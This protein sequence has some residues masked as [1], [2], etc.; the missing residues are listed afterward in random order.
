MMFYKNN[1]LNIFFVFLLCL[2]ANVLAQDQIIITPDYTQSEIRTKR[3]GL[4]VLVNKAEDLSFSGNVFI[5]F[6]E[7]PDNLTAES[8]GV[9]L[10]TENFNEKNYYFKRDNLDAGQTYYYRWRLESNEIGSL[11]TD[12]LSFTTLNGFG[13]LPGQVFELPEFANQPGRDLKEGDTIGRLKYDDLAGTW[14][15]VKTYFKTTMAL[16]ENGELWAWGRN[17]TKLVP[18]PGNQSEVIYEPSKIQNFSDGE[19]FQ[20]LV[21]EDNDGYWNIDEETAGTNP[22]DPDSIP[23]DTDQDGFSDMF[24]DSLGLDKNDDY[25]TFKDWEKLDEAYS[26]MV[27]LQDLYFYDFDFS[28]SAALGIE[29]N[30][31]NLYFWGTANGGGYISSEIEDLNGDKQGGRIPVMFLEK[32]SGE[33]IYYE[34]PV[35]IDN[36]RR[37][38]KIAVS[39]NYLSPKY[40]NINGLDNIWDTSVAGITE[41]G[42]LFIWGIV[43]GILLYEPLQVGTGYKW[44]DIAVAEGIVAITSN[45]ELFEV[46]ME[47]PDKPE[48][49]SIDLDGDG[50]PD[51]RDKF[52][53]DYN[54]QYDTD[55]DGL[56]DKYE[57]RVS[58]TNSNNRDTDGD[59]V[60]DG[61]DELPNDPSSS[62]D[63]D[64]DGLSAEKEKN[65]GDIDF[66]GVDG[67]QDPDRDGD[68]IP[69]G[70]DADPDDPN[71]KLDSDGDG[72]TDEQEWENFSD[73]FNPDSDQDGVG[74]FDDEFPGIWHYQNDSDGDGLPDK[75]ELIN[76]TNP[77]EIDSDGDG[78]IDGID[79]QKFDEFRSLAANLSCEGGWERCDQYYY[80]W[81]FWDLK[82]DCN[83]DGWISGDEWDRTSPDCE[84]KISRDDYPSDAQFTLDSDNDRE[85]DEIDEDDDNDGF[86]DKIEDFLGTDSKND[87]DRPEDS[88]DDRI[89][90]QIEIDGYVDQEGNQVYTRGTDQFNRDTDGDGAWDGWDDWPLDPRIS[91]DQDKDFIEDWRE[92]YELKTDHKNP[93]T[94]GD[95]VDDLYDDFPLK[96]WVTE[97]TFDSG[98]KDSD[99][100][101]LSDEYED[102]IAGLDKF[103]PD[104][105]GDGFEDGP[106]VEG[107]QR[108]FQNGEFVGW[109][110]SWERCHR[111]GENWYFDKIDNRW[112]NENSWIQDFFPTDNNNR[113]DIDG[114]GIPDNDDTDTDGDG[115]PNEEDDLPEDPTEQINTDKPTIENGGLTDWSW[116]GKKYAEENGT[117]PTNGNG[118]FGEDIDNDGWIDESRDIGWRFDFVGNNQDQDDDGDSFLD[119]DE[120]F[121]GTDPLDRLSFPGSSFADH[122]NDGLSTNFE[123]GVRI[124]K[125]R[126][127]N[128][129]N[130]TLIEDALSDEFD[131]PSVKLLND[132]NQLSPT[133]QF[134]TNFKV[135]NESG[136]VDNEIQ[137]KLYNSLKSFLPK[138]LTYDEFISTSS[139]TIGIIS[140][141]LRKSDPFNWDTDGDGISDGWRNPNDLS[142]DSSF[143]RFV[144]EIPSLEA[145]L[146]QG[147]IFKLK[148]EPYDS[149][150]YNESILKYEFSAT[151]STTTGLQLLQYFKEAIDGQL[152]EVYNNSGTIGSDLM[153]AT[154]SKTMLIVQ[155]KFYSGHHMGRYFSYN[156]FI[157]TL[158]NTSGSPKL[159][160]FKN[161]G[162]QEHL[163]V[164]FEDKMDTNEFMLGES[165]FREIRFK[166]GDVSYD[167]NDKFLIDDFPSD[168]SRYIDTD[169]DGLDDKEDNDIDGDGT[170]N[171][172]DELPWDSR[173]YKDIDNDGIPDEFDFTSME[174]DTDGDGMS[175]GDEI[176]LKLNPKNWDTDGDG[177]SDGGTYPSIIGEEYTNK[178]LIIEIDDLDAKVA[179]GEKFNIRFRVGWN[180]DHLFNIEYSHDSDRF[181]TEDYFNSFNGENLLSYFNFQINNQPEFSVTINIQNSEVDVK[182]KFSSRIQRVEG[183]KKVRLIIEWNKDFYVSYDTFGTTIE[184]N[185]IYPFVENF[186]QGGS[187][188]KYELWGLERHSIIDDDNW[189]KINFKNGKVIQGNVAGKKFI[190]AYPLDPDK[191]WDTDEDG[192]AD[193]YDNNI[194]GDDSKNSE[195]QVPYDNREVNDKDQ[196]GIGDTVDFT[197][198]YEDTDRDG[199]TNFYELE[200]SN[201]DPLNWDTDGDGVP[202]GPKYPHADV[203]SNRGLGLSG[204]WKFVVLV[205]NLEAKTISNTTYQIEIKNNNQTELITYD[206]PDVITGSAL[207]V[208]FKDK[209]NALSGSIGDDTW[210]ASI[211]NNRLI[212]KGNDENPDVEIRTPRILINNRNEMFVK[213]SDN[214]NNFGSLPGFLGEMMFRVT[215]KNNCC[216]QSSFDGEKFYNLF[217]EKRIQ[218]AFPNDP[219]KFWDTDGDGIADNFDYDIDGD[220][221]ENSIDAFPYLSSE[222]LD[223]DGDGIGDFADRDDNN[224]GRL[225]VDELYNNE[226]GYEFIDSDGDGFSDEYESFLGSNPQKWD[227]DNDGISDGFLFPNIEA[228]HRDYWQ[229]IVQIPNISAKIRAGESFQILWLG[230]GMD[231]IFERTATF[232]STTEVPAIN[233]LE[234]F[235]DQINNNGTFVTSNGVTTT[236][237]ATISSTMLIIK[238]DVDD[239]YRRSNLQ[240]FRA[241]VTVLR[242]D[243][244]IKEISNKRYFAEY[245]GDIYRPRNPSNGWS[246]I[247]FRY[248][249]NRIIKSYQYAD[250]D[251]LYDMFPND[252]DKFWDTDR[253]GI[254]DNFDYDIDGDNL[255]TPDNE[256]NDFAPYDT[257][258]LYDL[259]KDG[260]GISNDGFDDLLYDFDNDG[261]SNGYEVFESETNPYNYDTDGDGVSDGPGYPNSNAEVSSW[262]IVFE[263]PRKDLFLKEGDIYKAKPNDLGE[264]FE[265]VY[266]AKNG[267]TG[268]EL[269][270]YFKTKFEE[271]NSFLDNNLNEIKFKV[272]IIANKLIIE[273]VGEN[274]FHPPISINFP[275]TINHG[276]YISILKSQDSN[277]SKSLGSIMRDRVNEWCCS[278]YNNY[279]YGRFTSNSDGIPAFQDAF[280]NDST[281]YW[282]TDGDGIADNYDDDIDGDGFLNEN[283]GAPYDPDDDNDLDNDGSGDIND[284]QS[285]Y[286]DT[287][288]DGLINMVELEL[289]TDIFNWDTDGDKV[290]DGGNYPYFNWDNSID[291]KYIIDI[292]NSSLNM[293]PGKYLIRIWP[294]NQDGGGRQIIDG[295]LNSNYDSRRSETEIIL[296]I[297][298]D[299][300]SNTLSGARFLDDLAESINL[301]NQIPVNSYDNQQ[302]KKY[303]IIKAEVVSLDENDIRKRLIISGSDSQRDLHIDAFSLIHDGSFIYKINYNEWWKADHYFRSYQNQANINNQKKFTSTGNVT[304]NDKIEAIP[305]VD[306]YPNDASKYFDLD[307]DGSND[308]EDDDIDGDGISNFS[309][310]LPYDFS[311]TIDSDGDGIG[312]NKEQNKDNDNFLD[313]DEEFNGTNPLEWTDALG[314]L[315]SDSDGFSD[316]YERGVRIYKIRFANTVTTTLL[317]DALSN[318]FDKSIVKLLNNSNQLSTTIQFT[319]NY[320]V[321]EDTETVDNEIHTKLYTSLK[322]FL[323]KELTYEFFSTTSNTIGIISSQLRKS[324]PFNWDTDGDGYSDG[325]QYPCVDTGDMDW[326]DYFTPIELKLTI[327]SAD[328]KV[329]VG[330]KFVVVYE[331]RAMGWDRGLILSHTVTSSITGSQLLEIFAQKINEVGSIRYKKDNDRNNNE[332]SNYEDLPVS[333][334]VS[335]STLTLLTPDSFTDTST[336][337]NHGRRLWLATSFYSEIVNN[338]IISLGHGNLWNW[339]KRIESA[340]RRTDNCFGDKYFI[341]GGRQVGDSEPGGELLVD[342]FPNDP[343]EFWDTD[344]DGIGDN[345]DPDDDNDGLTDKEE[346]TRKGD[347]FS[348]RYSNPYL[349]DTDGDGVLDGEDGI[350]WNKDETLD[351]DGDYRGNTNEDNDDDNDGLSDEEENEIGTDPLSQDS[352]NDGYSDGC[353]GFG[354]DEY[355]DEGHWIETVSITKPSNFVIGK[356]GEYEI[357]LKGNDSDRYSFGGVYSPEKDTF[358]KPENSP[359][360]AGFAN[361]KR[362]QI[363]FPNGG[364]ITFLGSAKSDVN[365]RFKFEKMFWSENGNGDDDLQPLFTTSDMVISGEEYQ[366]YTIE[367]EPQPASNTFSNH[368][369]NPITPE[370]RFRMKD[371]VITSYGEQGNIDYPTFFGRRII[372]FSG[373][374]SSTVGDMLNYFESVINSFGE[375]E[376]INC[377]G[378]NDS[379]TQYK[380][381]VSAKVSGTNLII[382]GEKEQK[383]IQ[384]YFHRWNG[385][386]KRY[387]TSSFDNCELNRDQFP[388]DETEWYDSD[389]DNIGD[390]EDPNDDTDGLS[391]KRELELGTDPYYWDSDFDNFSDDNDQMPL[392]PSARWDI[393]GDGIPDER[394]TDNNDDGFI[395]LW[396][397]GDDGYPVDVD[398]DADGDGL[399]NV[400]EDE[401]SKTGRWQFDTDRD[402][403]GDGED[404]FPLYNLESLDT[405]SDGIGNNSDLDDDNDGYSDRDEIFSKTN[406]LSSTSYPLVDEDEDFISDLFES[407]IGTIVG[408]NDTDGDGIIDGYDAFP[409]NALEWFDTD[410]DGIGNN[411]DSNDD[412]DYLE[413][414]VEELNA[415]LGLYNT[416]SSTTFEGREKFNDLDNDQIPDELE[417]FIS[418]EFNSR[419]VNNQANLDEFTISY[420]QEIWDNYRSQTFKRIFRDESSTG[421]KDGVVSDLTFS[422]TYYYGIDLNNIS[423]EEILDILNVSDERRYLYRLEE[424]PFDPQEGNFDG[425]AFPN[426]QDPDSDN[427]GI[428]DGVDR[429][430]LDPNGNRD[431]DLDF[432]AD[433]NDPDLDNDGIP[434]YDELYLGTDPRNGD[435]DS[436]GTSDLLDFYPNEP[437]LQ[438]EN[439]LLG[440]LDVDQIGMI[441]NWSSISAWN[442]GQIGSSYAAINNDNDLFVWG[443]NYGALPAHDD[444][445]LDSWTNGINYAYVI[446]VDDMEKVYDEINWKNVSLGYKFGMGY[447]TEGEFFSWGRN[448]SSQLGLGKTSTFVKFTSPKIYMG[449]MTNLSTGDQQA[450]I[451]NI[452]GKL[453]MIGSNDQGQLGTG[454]PEFNV[455]QELDWEPEIPSSQIDQVKVTKTE[456]QILTRNKK[457]WA[458]GE[459]NYAQL[460]RGG[461]FTKA[462]NFSVQQIKEETSNWK[463]IHAISE[464]VYAFKADGTLWAWGRNDEYQLGIGSTSTYSAD[465]VQIFYHSTDPNQEKGGPVLESDVKEFSPVNGGFVFINNEGELFAAGVNFYTGK[466]FPLPRPRKI[467]NDNDWSKFHDFLGSEINILI[468][469]EDSSIWGAGANWNLVMT[470]NPCPESFKETWVVDITHPRQQVETEFE[471]SDIIGTA[472]ITLIIGDTQITESV[473]NSTSDFIQKITNTLGN[474]ENFENYFTVTTTL[475]TTGSHKITFKATNY[476]SHNFGYSISNKSSPTFSGNISIKELTPN[477]SGTTTYTL[478]INSVQFTSVGN[479]AD[480]FTANSANIMDN[481]LRDFKKQL[482]QTDK[483]ERVF[484]YTIS[485]TSLII[486][487]EVYDPFFLTSS[488]QNTSNANGTM[489]VSKTS[490]FVKVDCD[491]LNPFHS[492]LTMIFDSSNDWDNIS[493]GQ[494][495][496]IGLTDSGTIY[497]WGVNSQG[498]LG[499]SDV[500]NENERVGTP[501][502]IDTVSST[503]F[504]SVDASGEVSFAITED[505]EMFAWGDNDLGTLGVGDN[506]DKDEPV[507]VKTE[508]G[509]KWVEN[510]GGFRFQVGLAENANNQTVPYGWGYQ[511][512][513]E[514]GLLGK[515]KQDSI[516]WDTNLDESKGIVRTTTDGEFLVATKLLINYLETMLDFEYND[517]LDGGTTAKVIASSKAR[518]KVT[519]KSKSK[520]KGSQPSTKKMS[521]GKWKVKKTKSSFKGKSAISSA[522]LER[523]SGLE[524]YNFEIREVNERP[525][526][527]QLVDI[528]SKR[529]AKAKFLS[530]IIVTD[531][532]IDDEVT[533]TISSLSPNQDRFSIQN[534]KL[535]YEGKTSKAKVPYAVILTAT[536][537]EGLS[538]SKEFEIMEDEDGVVTIEEVTPTAPVDEIY[539]DNRVIDSDGDGFS[540]YDEIIAQTDPFDFRSSPTDFDNDGIFDVFDSDLD[541]DGYLNENDL[542]PYDATESRD[543]DGDGLGDNIDPDD[544]NDGFDDISVNWGDGYIVQDLFPNDPNESADFDRDGVGD[545]ADLD[546]DNDGYNDDIDAFPNNPF[547]WLDTDGDSIGDNSDDDSDND[548]YTDM[549]ES[550]LGTDP[551]LASDFPADMDNDFVPD[552]IDNDLD[553]DGVPNNFDNAPELYNPNQ[554]FVENDQNYVEIISPTFFT[555]NGDGKNDFW[556]IEELQRYPN[557]QVWLYDTSGNL[558]F[559][560]PNYN[561]NWDGTNNGV[562]TPE[563]SYLFLIDIDGDQEPDMQGW[564]YLAR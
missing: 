24:E 218:D 440:V 262:K 561:N 319:T 501:T 219:D 202:D 83:G 389:Y 287:D 112:Y 80:F 327:I 209:L 278:S 120:I 248:K 393:D 226:N 178:G 272:E 183:T 90:D 4:S 86:I 337:T 223:S 356:N 41:D 153:T 509:I 62:K 547:E 464:S 114:D 140:Y 161:D 110:W 174:L 118:I 116:N 420:F 401:V 317:E 258:N 562:P 349:T 277:Q 34:H 520:D 469:K 52:K 437:R 194:D 117:P 473:S 321:D 386:I 1:L 500:T 333:A 449:E 102:S 138:D 474:T 291:W 257:Q 245:L 381:P 191:F 505:G 527:I 403:F 169:G 74:D 17:S 411:K 504:V 71:K 502:L 328:K 311:E 497:S 486:Q 483:L 30:S 53:W 97:Q 406:T 40:P 330:E 450:G 548:G 131:N 44:E 433:R 289:K 445:S 458:Y 498:Q 177:V 15:K 443:L 407:E 283:D 492:K 297:E 230:E 78:V 512:F 480:S 47:I 563:A 427:D 187:N 510:L 57:Q 16:K 220:D 339:R 487:N 134:I 292:N 32:N 136:A 530:N 213:G 181:L 295:L 210:N 560:Q 550:L 2:S 214:A 354:F 222:Y 106:C 350:P 286:E 309:D 347:I 198:K 81:K 127:V 555:P 323:P 184:N 43:D 304:S 285:L 13:V 6:G 466:W 51:S 528:Q 145:T 301:L 478:S 167:S 306:A 11:S 352:D 159:H 515:V 542:F 186:W 310:D 426:I 170:S 205:P 290:S 438:Q 314:G 179:P 156:H 228:N 441:S 121:S 268:N 534:Q 558:I 299:Q 444:Q 204:N 27:T 482:E 288:K 130:T 531:P 451:I 369:I 249:W 197:G 164:V 313:L 511:K 48:E 375:I 3:A 5:D 318:E 37:W 242:G 430:P 264:N 523:N 65:N 123:N 477:I 368:I 383:N 298:S 99:Q 31:R 189:E 294:N 195:D 273:G 270:N 516:I 390:N 559:N 217:N 36:T 448:L 379:F 549:D 207:L 404:A 61:E 208:F 535:Y 557:N 236:L 111:G 461:A 539:Y 414:W 503:K 33:N 89:P 216:D 119:E 63:N 266:E 49:S 413:D 133:I 543:S 243:N 525:T 221:Y 67:D 522:D 18:S 371:I 351:T 359:E 452:D 28:R 521:V 325:W 442:H 271:K 185:L 163:N 155:G 126:F 269:L 408:K 39:D 455:P 206:S 109:Y 376:Y 358:F 367:I 8:V 320:K 45:G 345:S 201:T 9:I 12:L 260:I 276:N 224:N 315:D 261:L 21:D 225:D 508:S 415:I 244:T 312:N 533:V 364:R 129:V 496:S 463:S 332:E 254:A 280:P 180:S 423:L 479:G 263:I 76:E 95:G 494:K 519:S 73:P 526:D 341:R 157:T 253:D 87:R 142:D 422:A 193:N 154:I 457:V 308:F 419:I 342:M 518:S 91:Q 493:I 362:Q 241:P 68:G 334:T 235:R 59:G 425:D 484:T 25:I 22:Q 470:D 212:V 237:S 239:Q 387:T 75:L 395:D 506:S 513:G 544:D 279:Q 42:E 141:K 77:N 255:N 247:K 103:N 424:Y 293:S 453:R 104:S 472:S 113:R 418:N 370:A 256:Q 172:L 536:D 434:N 199:L 481:V 428:P 188:W 385:K 19:D 93:D 60:W 55:E 160:L 149:P 105:D 412:N 240:H 26:Q 50:V 38:E 343:T 490:S 144:I 246:N 238:N 203:S 326:D 399:T 282:D 537:F 94:D 471:F 382:E 259:D 429:A 35:L 168:P 564:I 366:E 541:N 462:E 125:I 344:G 467:G 10:P 416:T 192:T 166:N 147:D 250:A 54:Y 70:Y 29:R 72:L 137:T 489:T 499:L 365:L 529:T 229:N 532:D 421:A 454:A 460:G 346:L 372:S 316:I 200:V 267:D 234:Y 165:G 456:T 353:R 402:G 265:I 150:N 485:N 66:D 58:M 300:S 115:T 303:E 46:G 98:T 296:N 20:E 447:S 514:L 338:E 56:P 476:Q 507:K 135:D 88:D 524:L 340:D 211:W 410:G 545:N 64:G 231:N 139:N 82:Y 391:D 554:E 284:P 96:N 546:D 146:K 363:S 396:Y 151:N 384:V 377:C 405:D 374:E 233:M 495:H 335:G 378:N 79:V 215:T 361:Q 196:N 100:D 252:P 122:D 357:F 182:T 459:N 84:N 176:E 431:S 101:G 394:W 465:P 409:T 380:E 417:E 348:D 488:V 436:D 336:T 329:K 305:F 446:P 124:Y 435:S 517:G 491:D 128:T 107:I 400:Y 171:A 152:L 551:L 307:N 324:N 392:D 108:D 274:N 275:I 143:W 92:I 553:G 373:N 556:V 302:D 432:I 227:S 355:N 468:E 388:L 281:K 175:N 540:D 398:P 552:A 232:S 538:L 23:V 190:D 251:Y 132:S 85:P 14:L 360:W 162:R 331:G 148:I 173:S 439:D 69:D 322:S 397:G 7:N 158:D 475:T